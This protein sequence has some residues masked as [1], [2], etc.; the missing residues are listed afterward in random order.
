MSAYEQLDIACRAP[1]ENYRFALSPISTTLALSPISTRRQMASERDL[2]A[3]F[4][5]HASMLVV[6]S[7]GSQMPRNGSRLPLAGRPLFVFAFVDFFIL[8][9]RQLV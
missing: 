5:A 7:A 1:A 4:S 2:A 9:T 6:N 8:T 3:T